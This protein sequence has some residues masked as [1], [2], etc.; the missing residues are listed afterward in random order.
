M[1]LDSAIF[2]FFLAIVALMQAGLPGRGRVIV[3]LAASVCFYAAASVNYLILLLVLCSLN[4]WAVLGLS[5]LAGPRLRTWVFGGAVLI[6]LLVL[7]AFKYAGTL[8]GQLLAYCGWH[9]SGVAPLHLA[10]PLGLSYF[11]FQMLACVTDVYRGNWKLESGF[12]RFILFGFFFPQISSGPIPRAERLWPQLSSG[13]LPTTEDRLAGLRLITYGFFKKY[14]VANR[15][16]SYINPVFALPTGVGTLPVLM[17]CIFNALQLYADFSGYVDIAIGSARFLGIRL[18]PNFDRPFIST[19]ITELWRRWHMSLSFWLRDYLYMPLLIRIRNLG[20]VGVVLALVITFAICGLWHAAT[21]TYLLFGVSQ[22]VAMSVE[23]LTKSW[24]NK[25]L[26]K[27][28]KPLVGV[29]GRIYTLGFFILAEVMFRSMNVSQAGAIY[30]H[31]FQ[32]KFS[33][34][35]DYATAPEIKLYYL[36]LDCAAI[37]I[38]YVIAFWLRRTS[39]RTTPWFVL[40]CGLLILFLGRLSTAQFIYAAF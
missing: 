25:R 14:V 37:G 19:S 23:F 22:G 2:L 20:L 6:N 16:T 38:W 18:D 39:D 11:T 3:L 33:G 9:G 40:A 21:W 7:I 24:R 32:V 12:F 30:R 28:P 31:L 34:M 17:A 13:G 36:L 15:L 1:G 26:K 27:F 4:Y 35:F 8:I 29:A 10:T 5:R